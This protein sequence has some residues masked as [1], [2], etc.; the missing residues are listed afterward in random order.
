[1]EVGERWA[2]RASPFHG[3]VS[4]VEVLKLGS[5]RPPRVKVRF[6]A[7]EAEGRQEWVSPARLRVPWAQRDAWQAN[8][9]RWTELA[10]DGPD[11]DAA[12]HRAVNLVFDESP[13]E[14]L[15]S[16]ARSYRHRGVLHIHDA[17][18]LAAL[19]HVPEDT[20]RSDRALS[21]TAGHSTSPGPPPSP[22]LRSSPAPAPMSCPPFWPGTKNK[23]N[24]APFTG[25]STRAASSGMYIQPEICAEVDRE[26]QPAHDLVREWCGTEATDHRDELTALRAEVVRIGKLAERAIT[27]LREAGQQHAADD[28]ER[29]LGVPLETLRQA[30]T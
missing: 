22:S 26:R 9:Q 10:C 20:F 6:T 11:D 12:E 3:P 4:E 23:V 17:P 24:S 13:L 5:Q 1:M 15:V 18:A 16:L 8:Q 25:S 14:D 30:D 21:Q 28:L 27:R 29:E 2:Y 19:L 7:E